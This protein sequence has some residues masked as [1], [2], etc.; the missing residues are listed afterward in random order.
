MFESRRSPTVRGLNP[1][2]WMAALA[3]LVFPGFSAVAAP[4]PVYEN[5]GNADTPVIDATTFL[6]RGLFEVNAFDQPYD[7]QNTLNY[8]DRKS[9]V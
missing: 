2:L 3:V 7:T 6:N 9:V 1:K 4:A 8:T 5:R